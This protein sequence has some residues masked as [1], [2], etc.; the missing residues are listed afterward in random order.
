MRQL[1]DACDALQAEPLHNGYAPNFTNYGNYGNIGF[2][3]FSPEAMAVPTPMEIGSSQAQPQPR[4]SGMQRQPQGAA[5]QRG[6]GQPLSCWSCGRPGH[7]RNFCP[8]R[9]GNQGPTGRPPDK[10]SNNQR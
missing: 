8:E 2:D 3:G 4:Q 1:R 7:T 9:R 5:A 10:S 6:Y